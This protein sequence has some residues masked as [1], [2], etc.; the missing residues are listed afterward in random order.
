[1][2]SIYLISIFLEHFIS[3]DTTQ[4][5]ESR[6]KDLCSDIDVQFRRNKTKDTFIDLKISREHA[7]N[8]EFNMTAPSSRAT[9]LLLRGCQ[10]EPDAGG[11]PGTGAQAHNVHL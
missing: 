3:S 9:R 6:Y 5:G 10:A 1:M 4:G 2:K 7:L 8:S 11:R